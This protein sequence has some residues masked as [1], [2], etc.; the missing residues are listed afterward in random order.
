LASDVTRT[1]R[2]RI[3]FITALS[4]MMMQLAVAAHVCAAQRTMALETMEHPCDAGGTTPVE[5]R[6]DVCGKHCNIGYQ[7]VDQGQPVHLVAL[8]SP[9]ALRTDLPEAESVSAAQAEWRALAQP[10]PPDH[11]VL[12]CCFRL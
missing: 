12:H 2:I 3:A 5:D 10:P 8:P 6:S 4:V 9:V 7:H 1:R 11:A